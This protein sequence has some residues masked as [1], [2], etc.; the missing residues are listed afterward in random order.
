MRRTKGFTLVELLVVIAIIALLM[1]ILMPAL[2]RVRAIAFRMTC[3]TNLAGIGKAMLIY[4]NDYE[5][6]LPRA[7]WPNSILLNHLGG[8]GSDG[9]DGK[10]WS[11]GIRAGAFGDEPAGP[12]PQATVTS[13]FYTLIKLADVT[14]K[15]F[16]C[17][18]DS[19]VKEFKLADFTNDPEF[20]LIDAW[21]FG[22]ADGDSTENN[23]DCRCSYSY[24]YPFGTFALTTSSEP[25]MA[26]AADPNPWHIHADVETD[27]TR[28]TQASSTRIGDTTDGGPFGSEGPYSHKLERDNVRF[29]NSNAHQEEGQNVLFAD[30]HVAFEKTPFCGSEEDNV[31]T[32]YHPGRE[33]Q[34]GTK[35]PDPFEPYHRRDSFLINNFAGP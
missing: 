30:G 27:K 18:S 25:G 29:G 33:R 13:C 11:S 26:V 16:Y 2:A 32:A 34:I 28:T 14:P 6:E 22:P 19:G 9:P 10:P 20:E 31:Y 17:K 3:G 4:A 35:N 15:S 21:D 24:H 12:T 8:S 7:G 23:P 1:G 5:D